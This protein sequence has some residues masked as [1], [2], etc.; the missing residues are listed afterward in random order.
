MTEEFKALFGQVKNRCP[1]HGFTTT[2]KCLCAKAGCKNTIEKIQP[3]KDP[4]PTLFIQDELHLVKESLG[5]FDSH[6]E[7]FL[8]V[9]CRES[10]S[11]GA[12]KEDQIH[13]CNGNNFYV[14][15]TPWKFVSP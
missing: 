5:T 9:L 8:E 14:Q 7:S 15:R 1:I 4:I 12:K 11:T 2:S 6:Y 3:L 10:S 13:R